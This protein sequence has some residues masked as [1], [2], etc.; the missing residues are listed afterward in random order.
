MVSSNL[1][2]LKYD[3]NSSNVDVKPLTFINTATGAI[4]SPRSSSFFH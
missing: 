2:Q 4:T 1:I 3:L